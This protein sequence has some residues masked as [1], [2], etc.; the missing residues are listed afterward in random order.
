MNNKIGALSGVIGS[1]SVASVPYIP[2]TESSSRQISSSDVPD[3]WTKA[4]GSKMSAQEIREAQ[5]RYL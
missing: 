5:E 3:I 2:S 1:G 4:D